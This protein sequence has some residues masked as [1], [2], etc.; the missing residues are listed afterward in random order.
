MVADGPPQRIDCRPRVPSRADLSSTR[1]RLCRRLP[2]TPC[3]TPE[4]AFDFPLHYRPPSLRKTTD[5]QRMSPCQCIANVDNGFGAGYLA[6]TIN[7]T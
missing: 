1:N 3:G 5:V 4:I 6:A 2:Q 7:A